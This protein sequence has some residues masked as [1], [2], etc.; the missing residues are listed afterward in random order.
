MTKLLVGRLKPTSGN[1]AHLVGGASLPSGI[2]VTRASVGTSYNSA[3]YITDVVNDTAR[4]GTKAGLLIEESRQNLC[5]FSTPFNPSVSDCVAST[6][7]IRAPDGSFNALRITATSN[8]QGNSAWTQR[9][10][11]V[12]NDS[13]T[14]TISAYI[15]KG[16]TDKSLLYGIFSTGSTS[17]LAATIVW[18]LRPEDQP[19]FTNCQGAYVSNG[20]WRVWLNLSNNTSGNIVGSVRVYIK[21]QVAD[22]AAGDYVDTWGWQLEVGAYPTSWLRTAA[23]AVT[24]AQESASMAMS[25][26]MPSTYASRN[27]VQRSEQLDNA[28]WV[29]ASITGVTADAATDPL[30]TTT[31]DKIIPDATVTTHYIRQDIAAIAVNDYVTASVFLKAAEIT[32]ARLM[33]RDTITNSNNC[34]ANLDLSTG[35]QIG[36]ITNSGTASGGVSDIVSIGSG[37]YRLSLTCQFSNATTVRMEI[38]SYGLSGLSTAGDGVSGIYAWGALATVARNVPSYVQTVGAQAAGATKGTLLVDA[39]WLNAI[40]TANSIVL[41]MYD[42]ANNQ[43]TLFQNSAISKLTVV[44]IYSGLSIADTQFFNPVA[45]TV[46]TK[47]RV[48]ITWDSTTRLYAVQ[49][50]V[51][52]TVSGLMTIQAEFMHLLTTLG[53][54]KNASTFSSEV[55]EINR[56]DFIRTPVPASGLATLLA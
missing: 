18:G 40:P 48:A 8:V 36:S 14:Y 26:I 39:T 25:A 23:S 34:Q 13:N 24:R 56:V 33:I 44:L 6:C 37:W 42:D 54:G 5:I 16:N 4:F 3:G 55:L 49:F 11:S 38:A 15:R 12:P 46:G 27:L 9:N 20:W 2:S 30:G 41:S 47:F 45:A 7:P 29:R 50:N 32:S 35:L 10:S 28:I 17:Q 43:L 53:L 1:A 31:A 21:T 22:Y 19:T 51:G 52:G